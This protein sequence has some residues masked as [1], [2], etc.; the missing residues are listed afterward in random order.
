MPITLQLNVALLAQT[1]PAYQ[2]CGHFCTA[3]EWLPMLRKPRHFVS[4]A[5]WPQM[6]CNFP[7]QLGMQATQVQH[8]PI[9]TSPPTLHVISPFTA[10]D[11]NSPCPRCFY[12]AIGPAA[13][14]RIQ[15]SDGT[16]G[17][18]QG[19][20][21]A[22]TA[23]AG[24]ATAGTAGTALGGTALGGPQDA[25]KICPLPAGARGRTRSTGAAA[26]G[27]GV[28][29]TGGKAFCLK[30]SQMDSDGFVVEKHTSA[31][32][33]FIGS[34]ADFPKFHFRGICAAVVLEPACRIQRRTN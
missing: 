27:G 32:I 9:P 3:H 28:K 34:G 14:R 13:L 20:G 12:A 16:G 4:S 7:R 10:E 24:T 2:P 21:T 31:Y 33:G 1:L 22:G 15:C 5:S 8:G 25:S 26:G 17:G 18:G 23:T 29:G 11:L 19:G 30:R 6:H